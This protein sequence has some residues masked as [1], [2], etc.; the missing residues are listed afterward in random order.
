MS[1]MNNKS[2]SQILNMNAGFMGIQFGW[3][4]QMANM[5]AIYEYLGAQPDQIPF[6][7]LAA[8]LTGLIVQPIIGQWSDQTWTRLGRRRPFFLVGAILSS[9]ALVVMPHSNTLLMAASLLWVL[10]A[11]INISMEPFRAFV[12]D[13]LPHE[14]RAFGFATQSMFIGLGSIMASALPWLMSNA[15]KGSGPIPRS[16]EYSFYIGAFFFFAAIL[17]T[18]LTTP[19]TPP[20]NQNSKTKLSF[21]QQAS[22]LTSSFRNIPSMMWKL[23]GV[24]C[25][26]WMGLF[27]MWLYFPIAVGHNVFMAPDE[28]SPLYKQ[29]IEWAGLCFAFYSLVCF[30]YSFALPKIAKAI[31]ENKTHAISLLAGGLGLISVFLIHNQYLLLI[32]MFGVGM[33]WASTLSMPYSMLSHHLPENKVGTYMGIFNFAIV[34]PE[35]FS[36]LTLGLFVRLVLNNDRLMAVIM[37]GGFMIIAAFLSSRLPAEKHSHN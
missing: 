19:E 8:P 4:L 9:I 13:Q 33:A 14:Q 27:C 23:M 2:L 6:L 28:T 17:W 11:S 25:F 34:I 18:I 26:T 15:E 1:I 21:G 10:D 16:I 22:E 32:S 20:E 5:S 12:S 3:G 7:W 37:G 31:G 24:Q 30:L 29:G 35:I 36:A